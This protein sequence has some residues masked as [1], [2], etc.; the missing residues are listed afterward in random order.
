MWST[1]SDY[2]KLTFLKKREVNKVLTIGETLLGVPKEELGEDFVYE[3]DRIITLLEDFLHKDIHTLIWLINSRF[4]ALIVGK[5]FKP[6]KN[7]NPTKREKYM[8]KW[9]KSRIPIFRTSY[10]T[11]RAFASWAYYTSERGESEINFPG[12]TIGREHELPTL[13]YG[14]EPLQPESYLEEEYP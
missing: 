7:M 9:M 5:S 10:V 1:Y 13:L 6:L 12:L 2:S 3:L 14:K 11:L 8:E 4:A